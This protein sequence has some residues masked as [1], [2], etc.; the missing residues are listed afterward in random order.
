MTILVTGVA[1]H[2]GRNTVRQLVE[3]G[4]DVRALTR[5]SRSGTFRRESGCTRAISPAH[6]R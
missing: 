4:H 2:A 6:R 1:G 5:G 3:T